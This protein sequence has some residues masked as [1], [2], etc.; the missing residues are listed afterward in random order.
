MYFGH[1]VNLSNNKGMSESANAAVSGNNVYVVWQD[2]STGNG[3]IYLR[4]STDGGKA[5]EDILNLSNNTGGS[6]LPQIA[7]SGNNV[8][9]VWQDNSTGNGD[10]YLKGST[11]SGA[12]FAKRKNI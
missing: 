12:D 6:Q 7:L 4:H 8:Y 5:F 1:S 10:I 9:V 11:N 3:D 2:N